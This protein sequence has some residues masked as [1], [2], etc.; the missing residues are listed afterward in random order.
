M[1][2]FMRNYFQINNGMA[3][4]EQQMNTLMA[5][6]Q[7]MWQAVLDLMQDRERQGTV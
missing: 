7:T 4:H 3:R 6:Q 2:K 1:Q 5:S